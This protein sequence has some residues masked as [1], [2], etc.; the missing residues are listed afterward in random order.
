[1]SDK[2]DYISP[3]PNADDSDLAQFPKTHLMLAGIDPLRDCSID[4]LSRLLKNGVDARA[5]EMDMMPHGYLSIYWVKDRTMNEAKDCIV[6]SVE[7]LRSLMKDCEQKNKSEWESVP[8][9]QTSKTN[10]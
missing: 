3:G 9:G 4:F 2:N 1:M 8:N 6:K 7:I 5:T 10:K